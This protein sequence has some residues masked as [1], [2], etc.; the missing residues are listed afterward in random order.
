MP[1][2][3]KECDICEKEC[4]TGDACPEA[5]LEKNYNSNEEDE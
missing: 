3:E 2:S 4:H 5:S 1:N